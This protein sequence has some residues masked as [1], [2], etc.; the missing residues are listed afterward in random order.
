[1]KNNFRPWIATILSFVIAGLGQ[2]YVGSYA[3]GLIYILLEI[4]AY[5][6]LT[7]YPEV[8]LLFSFALEVWA[9]FEAY[10]TAV[11]QG[12]KGPQDTGGLEITSFDV[13]SG[14]GR[15]IKRSR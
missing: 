14:W 2:L 1:M 5:A 9:S 10:K 13:G 15:G 7:G 6:G 3:K 8:L 12:R 4:I 11:D